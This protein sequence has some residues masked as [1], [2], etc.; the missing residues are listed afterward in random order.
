MEAQARDEMSTDDRRCPKCGF[1]ETGYF[2][3][4]CGELLRGDE[5][6]LCPRC[7]Q[8]VPRG[9]YCNQCGQGLDDLALDLRQLAWAGEAFWVTGET[10]LPPSSPEPSLLAPDESVELAH[11]E[12]P[13][14]LQELPAGSA[15]SEVQQHIYPAL[16]PIQAQRAAS[17]QRRFLIVVILLTGL[18]LLS[19]V[20]MALYVLLGGGA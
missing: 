14:W 12:L 11:A 13:D 19:V 20:L 9:D 1:E 8:V 2:C 3:R 6:V 10:A 18:L 17:R 5:L 16:R 15:P 7:R 4:N